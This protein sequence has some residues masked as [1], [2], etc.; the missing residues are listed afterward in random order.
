MYPAR[1]SFTVLFLKFYKL[2]IET[3][4]LRCWNG[5]TFLPV[6]SSKPALGH[7]PH[8]KHLALRTSS[9]SNNKQ[10]SDKSSAARLHDLVETSGGTYA[11]RSVPRRHICTPRSADTCRLHTSL[12][13][14]SRTPPIPR[15][16]DSQPFSA[17]IKF[18]TEWRHKRP[19]AARRGPAS[20]ALHRTLYSSRGPSAL[21]A[22]V[23]MCVSVSACVL[24]AAKGA[25]R[26]N[27][28]D[29]GSRRRQSPLF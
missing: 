23:C 10:G 21:R 8:P 18:D 26:G 1:L 7:L 5:S 9:Q 13:L 27:T 17:C 11:S 15:D 4:C 6:S 29:A 3:Q 14:S 28:R 22:S 19:A 16:T 24:K 20:R 12:A 2:N 25:G